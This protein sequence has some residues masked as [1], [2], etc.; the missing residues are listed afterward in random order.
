MQHLK[1]FIAIMI[2]AV[3]YRN[4]CINF[5]LRYYLIEKIQLCNRNLIT[6]KASLNF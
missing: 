1:D 6:T 4:L 2:F 3:K 5:N